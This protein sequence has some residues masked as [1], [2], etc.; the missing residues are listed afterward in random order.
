MVAAHKG[1]FDSI[2]LLRTEAKAVVDERTRQLIVA[3]L[4]TAAAVTA[5]NGTGDTLK[6]SIDAAGT[7]AAI[8]AV[9]DDR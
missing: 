3:D 2:A 6:A 9:E 5:H 4:F 8:A 1:A 7:R